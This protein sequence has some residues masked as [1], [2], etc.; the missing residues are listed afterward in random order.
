L[1]AQCD[2][3]ALPHADETSPTLDPLRRLCHG[4]RS[5]FAFK[6]RYAFAD[7]DAGCGLQATSTAAGVAVGQRANV[8]GVPWVNTAKEQR[9]PITDS[10]AM[11]SVR[12]RTT[13]SV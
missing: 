9:N 11:R 5:D 2:W 1:Q 4:M 7:G 3:V 13:V 10:K 12:N 8:R 6:V